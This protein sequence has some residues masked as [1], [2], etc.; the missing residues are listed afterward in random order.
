MTDIYIS[1]ISLFQNS[2]WEERTL[3]QESLEI[4]PIPLASLPPAPWRPLPSIFLFYFVLLPP[5]FILHMH[6]SNI[7]G[8]KWKHFFGRGNV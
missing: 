4:I 5:E 7:I 3:C 6:I 1:N 2:P 8:Q